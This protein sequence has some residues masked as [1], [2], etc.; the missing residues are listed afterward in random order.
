MGAMTV[1]P[2]IDRW[3]AGRGWRVR[4]H[5]AEMLD[6][7]DDGRHALLVADTGAGKTL[8]GF[9][10]TLA[11][12][13]PSRLDGTPVPEGLHT[14]Y[15]SP[16]KALAHDVQRN[17][18]APIEEMGLPIRV[19]TRSGDTPSDRKKRQRARPPHV[20]LTTPE[21]LSLLL[22][23][24]DSLAMFASLRRIVID[25]VHA[26][27]TGK[28]GDLLALALSR[29]QAIAP[30]MKRAA[31]SATVADPQAF[32]E[33][34]AP[35]GDIDRV[36]LVEGEQGAPPQVEILLPDEERVP[37]GGHAGRWAIP[38]LYE[39]IRRNR[40]TLV[41]TNTRFLA[42]FVFELLWDAN[43]DNLPIGI[44]HGSLSKEAR[45][46][47]EG[48]MARGELRALV[49]TASL[50]LGVDWGD[51]DCVVQMGA[52]KGSSRLLQR[53]GRANHRLDQ[54]SRAILVPGNRFEFL[55]AMAAK[56]AVDAGQRDGEDFRPGSLDVL[57][58]H[59]MACAC[60]APF[61]ESGLL[62]E[63]RSS[64]AYAWIDAEV[65]QRVLNFVA[66]GGYALKA[67]DRFHRIVRE[68]GGA[69]GDTNGGATWR[70]AHPE[71]AA[72]HR[73]N[74][75]I[76]VDSEMLDVRFR[77]GRSLGK[78]EERFAAAL[79]PGD[80]FRFAGMTL[81][82][83][84]IK[85]MELQ[86]RASKA[87]ATI[88]SYGGQRLPLTTHLAG[89]VR[90]ML[91]DRA[92][93]ARFPDDVREWLEV[94][95]WRSRMPGPGQLLVESFPHGR[96]HFSV[97]Y[98]FEGWNANQSL[99]MLITRRMEERGLSPGGFIANDYSL[100]VWG[101]R[102]VTDPAPLLSP[103][104]LA[105]EF[106]DWVTESHLL[107]RAFREVAVI[108]GLVERQHPGKRK[109]GKQV[110]F[111]TD[112]IYDVLRKYEPDHVLL[113]AA[114]ADARSRMTDVARLAD[115][116]DRAARE[117]DHVTLDRVSPLAVP[118]MTMIGR[119]DV[120]Q[121]AIDDDLLLEAETLAATAMRTEW[122]HIS[123]ED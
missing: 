115:L 52:P 59:V 89:R 75:G 92:G 112:L 119:E 83:E 72:R 28:R 50:D 94:Q 76:I 81:E 74:A 54:P 65:W 12:F 36:A 15:V 25:E 117:L 2:E 24:P 86:V 103:D 8:A 82:V 114:W 123:D 34:L 102:P 68:P 69:D 14:L 41:F 23:Y 35:W 108:S 19:E 3:F 100:A 62:A 64:L 39:E 47:V 22:S 13:C 31:L 95:D 122:P 88:P 104:I 43:D 97:Y 109:S 5:Q 45:R 33:W 87:A 56:D 42:E 20:L 61:D 84:Q 32:R 118:V 7:S 58:Q 18:M 46:K 106:V 121:G 10:P 63:V 55:E 105:H 27:A 16:L 60:A 70:L 71:H 85:D 101:L 37:W 48:A 99:G 44:H 26:F 90:E 30:Q 98:T 29:L 49:A 11:D 17:L 51:I 38:Q 21:S 110:T 4:R 91:V 9:L 96:K 93:W 80:T 57:A 79:S 73:M 113:E 120:P 77:N 66:T 107:R 1:P 111:S 40:T 6:A 67:Y 53:I 78:V 116:L